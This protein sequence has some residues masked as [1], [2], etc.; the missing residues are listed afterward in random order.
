MNIRDQLR[1]ETKGHQLYNIKEEKYKEKEKDGI[2]FRVSP[3]PFKLTKEQKDEMLCI[4]KAIC[5][6]MD[7][8]IELYSSN[9]EVKEILDRGKPKEYIGKELP[10]Y[11]FLRPDLILTETG[12][13]ICE[14]ETSPFGLGLA[15]ILNRTY[16]NVGYDPLVKQNTLKNYIQSR[17]AN[18]G[19]IA[20]SDKVKSFK[21]QLDFLAE[22]IFSGNGKKWDSENISHNTTSSEEIYRAF[23]LNDAYK[24]KNI[25]LFLKEPHLHIPSKTP[26][27]EEKALMSFIWDKRYTKFFEEQLGKAEYNLLKKAIPK[28]WIL[29]EENY[30]EGGLPE[31]KES[32]IDIATLGKSKRQFVLKSSGFNTNSSWG[33]GVVFLH[34]MGGK[35]AGEKIQSAINDNNHLYIMQEYKQGKNVPMI[36]IDENTQEKKQVKAKVRITP[37]FSYQPGNKGEL[38]AAKVTG[39]ENTEYVH[40]SSASINSAIIEEER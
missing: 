38:I 3:T 35:V 37:Y 4:G 19:T 10:N 40:A 18:E 20:Y 34:K 14:I 25:E 32:S 8:C 28:T 7:A 2:G 29:G 6:Y 13:S 16:G 33:E 36:Y 22:E 12:F 39:C 9:Q 24:D 23:Y 15:E 30:I 21:G 31:G 27:F 26:Q 1:I 5:N 11:L 17:T